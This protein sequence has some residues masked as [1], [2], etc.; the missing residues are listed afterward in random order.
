MTAPPPALPFRVTT[1]Q[2]ADVFRSVWE[3]QLLLHFM[4]PGGSTVAAL[5]AAN[6]LS[7]NA[8]YRKVQ[9]LCQVGLLEVLREERRSG[10]A[11]KVY[12]CPHTSFFIP[13]G[14]ISLEEQITE[15][16][17]PYQELIR[18]KLIEASRQGPNPVEGLIFTVGEGGLWLLPATAD[19]ERW[20]PD[21]P[22]TPAHLHSSGP[23]YLDYVQARALERELYELFD[24][25]REYRGANPYLLH[26][27][28]VPIEGLSRFALPHA[29]YTELV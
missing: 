16:F 17:E 24:R 23:L 13:R 20:R 11:I 19:G 28:L 9:K 26:M 27:A 15:T 1:S 3:F 29:G 8:A 5:A 22:G 6:D 10:R 21:F 14:L 25:Y 12:H 4:V 18:Q 2:V 7:V